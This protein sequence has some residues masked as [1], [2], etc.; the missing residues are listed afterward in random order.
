MK[1][2]SNF[3]DVIREEK[4]IAYIVNHIVKLP[5]NKFMNNSLSTLSY[6]EA[7]WQIHYRL[8]VKVKEKPLH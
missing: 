1:G 2:I 7:F 6:V 3:K 8:F 4:N 5:E